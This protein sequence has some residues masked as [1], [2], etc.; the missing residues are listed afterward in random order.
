MNAWIC[1]NANHI[2]FSKCLLSLPL[3]KESQD[4]ATL[5]SAHFDCQEDE[6][7]VNIPFYTAKPS[8]SHGDLVFDLR[9]D[10]SQGGGDDVEHP[11]NITM[12]RVHLASDTCDIYSTY[13]EVNHLLYTCS[14]DPFDDGILLRIP[15]VCMHR[16]C[17][18]VT[19]EEEEC[20]HQGTPT[21]SAREAWKR[22][23]SCSKATATR[24]LTIHRTSN[25]NTHWPAR[26]IANN[27]RYSGRMTDVTPDVRHTTAPGRPTATGNPA[28]PVQRRNVGSS[29]PSGRPDPRERPDDRQPS[30][31]RHCLRADPRVSTHVSVSHLPLRGLD[32]K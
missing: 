3:L 23:R 6:Y 25:T 2:C 32:Y 20:K 26:R 29:T 16:Y 9:S 7:L 22:R 12:S 11:T 24:R 4:A 13:I 30:G 14:L 18:S 8:L 21:P 15:L 27:A 28:T 19:D 17:R 1:T 5:E 31:V 10:L